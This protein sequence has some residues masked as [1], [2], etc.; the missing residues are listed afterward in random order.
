MARANYMLRL[1]AGQEAL[2]PW[3]LSLVHRHCTAVGIPPTQ[4]GSLGALSFWVSGIHADRA[5]RTGH[6]CGCAP[7]YWQDPAATVARRWLEQDGLGRQWP[8]LT[9]GRP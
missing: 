7:V 5:A 9:G 4:A 6:R 1:C 8:A 2:S 3:L